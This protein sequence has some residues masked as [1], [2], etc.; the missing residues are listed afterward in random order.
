MPLFMIV[1]EG[2][3]F[4]RGRNKRTA[5]LKF[6]QDPAL[7]AEFLDQDPVRWQ[8]LMVIADILQQHMDLSGWERMNILVTKHCPYFPCTHCWASDIISSRACPTDFATDAL[9]EIFDTYK[10]WMQTSPFADW[11]KKPTGIILGGEPF[12]FGLE[13]EI[14]RLEDD[15]SNLPEPT[16]QFFEMINKA[17]R[18]F[19]TLII[20]TNGF[21]LPANYLRLKA[22][23]DRLP[24]NVVI[25]LS[26]DPQH[27]EREKHSNKNGPALVAGL[28]RWNKEKG[29]EGR[30]RYSALMPN[31]FTELQVREFFR[32]YGIEHL[33]ETLKDIFHPSRLLIEYGLFNLGMAKKIPEREQRQGLG[34]AYQGGGKNCF[35]RPDGFV[36]DS[37]WTAAM[38]EM[39]PS[40]SL[41]NVFQDSLW[42]IFLT[43]MKGNISGLLFSFPD[44]LIS[45]GE[46][47]VKVL[48]AMLEKEKRR[49]PPRH[50]ADT[51]FS[52]S[53]RHLPVV[54]VD[55]AA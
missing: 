2:W 20:D 34:K 55:E 37:L 14:N 29:N 32:R 41:G 39:R 51:T 9:D 13:T 25:Q 27:Q 43:H 12:A 35:I 22:L 33:I 24:R 7:A 40:S 47:M 42:S 19:E 21:Y 18:S 4:D 38:R 10:N 11:S 3:D 15:E 1:M 8:H 48:E 5:L 17:A 6:V 53:S 45:Q 23:L 16:L 28:E 36:T 46:Q 44:G 31:D 49:N 52:P 30:V 54:T 50:S 26:L